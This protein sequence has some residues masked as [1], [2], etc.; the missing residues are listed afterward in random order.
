M[1]DWTWL[2]YLIGG[3]L[4]VLG[5]GVV[6]FAMFKGRSRGRKRCPRCWYDMSASPTLLC[7]ECGRTARSPRHL[8]KTRRR[9][10]L[11]VVGMMVVLLGGATAVGPAAY[12]GKWVE[13]TPASVL[14][15][16]L[17]F[18]DAE[19]EREYNNTFG[20]QVP[21]LGTTP[22]IG[23]LFTSPKSTQSVWK[24]LLIARHCANRMNRESPE[25]TGPGADFFTFQDS[26]EWALVSLG[27]NAKPAFPVL[28]NMIGSED[29]RRRMDAMTIIRHLGAGASG[30][31]PGLCDILS[32]HKNSDSREAAAN[33][34]IHLSPSTRSISVLSRAA[35]QD[36]SPRVRSCAMLCIGVLARTH[37]EL[38]AVL[39]QSLLDEDETVRE[40]GVISLGAQVCDYTWYS[41]LSQYSSTWLGEVYLS[42]ASS[43][44]AA[45]PD[46]DVL[47][48]II[49]AL[50][51]PSAK[52]RTAVAYYLW[53]T[54]L[55]T[56]IACEAMRKAAE[57]D[58]SS[59]ARYF[60]ARALERYKKSGEILEV[61]R[62]IVQDH[63]EA[64]SLWAVRKLGALG[65]V[66]TPAI[67]D[68]IAFS[69]H[70]PEQTSVQCVMNLAMIPGVSAEDWK[71]FLRHEL[72]SVRLAAVRAFQSSSIDADG[73]SKELLALTSDSNTDIVICAIRAIKDCRGHADEV[74]ARLDELLDR[75]KADDSTERLRIEEVAT[76]A[77]VGRDKPEKIVPMLIRMLVDPVPL[78]RQHVAY[79]LGKLGGDAATAVDALK[80]RINDENKEVRERAATAV[81]QITGD[82]RKK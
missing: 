75:A 51:D 47:P 31:Q 14:N 61:L 25:A 49:A 82:E 58:T 73:C 77:S 56:S 50:G 3:C 72:A 45:S 16:G 48:S 69:T 44:M 17:S 70:A 9:W 2:S 18:F 19:A 66:A 7:S 65:P 27:V 52:V 28:L 30:L 71:P 60:L 53:M 10:R 38:I 12:T 78:F 42:L 26:T 29:E 6:L 62:L 1:T 67:P 81:E 76:L 46:P 74:I 21:L 37:T 34:L 39:Q 5:L 63:D 20:G 4:A 32:R 55:D 59:I 15:F 36:A 11:A 43:K 13:Y 64:Y 57:K 79:Q 8:L 24:Q 23:G 41:Q 54:P 68:V 35:T 40:V 33:A 22:L 80:Q